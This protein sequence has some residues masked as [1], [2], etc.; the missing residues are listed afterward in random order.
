MIVIRVDRIYSMISS[1]LTENNAVV[2]RKTS[3]RRQCWYMAVA[4]IANC[5]QSTGNPVR[6]SVLVEIIQ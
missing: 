6:M 4:Y 1:H 5:T 2:R 3:C